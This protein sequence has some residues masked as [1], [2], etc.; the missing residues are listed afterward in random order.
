MGGGISKAELQQALSKQLESTQNANL[1]LLTQEEGASQALDVWTD[2]FQKDPMMCWVGGLEY[3]N[4]PESTKAARQDVAR[5]MLSWVNDDHLNG[6]RGYTVGIHNNEQQE[7]LVGAMSMATS[8]T[9][10]LGFLDT[11]RMLWKYGMPPMNKKSETTNDGGG[12]FCPNAMQRLQALSVL[13]KKR[14]QHMDAGNSKGNSKWIYLQTI[15]VLM[16]HQGGKGKYGSTM[17][18]FLLQTATDLNVP[19]YLE[20]ESKENESFYQHFGF[21]TLEKVELSVP[22]DERDDAILLMYLMRWSPPSSGTT[23]GK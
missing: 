21:E 11:M 8:S 1:V 22:G 4:P 2:S 9:A 16:E 6:R 3:E 17:L 7:Q 13:D 23:G 15:G 12:K 10:T 19:V 20:T 18:R 5:W 14:H